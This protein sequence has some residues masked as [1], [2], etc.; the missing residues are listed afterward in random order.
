[1]DNLDFNKRLGEQIRKIRKEK[2]LTQAALAALMN[3]DPQNISSYERGERCPSLFWVGRLCEALEI[4]PVT[5]LTEVYG[6]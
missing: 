4:S 2:N 6:K 3:I 1:M 5:F